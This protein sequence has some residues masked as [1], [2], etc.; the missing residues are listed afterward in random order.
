MVGRL[1]PRLIALA[2]LWLFCSQVVAQVPPAPTAP[3]TGATGVATA[4]GAAA[5]AAPAPANLWSF[6]CMTPAQKAACKQKLCACPLVQ[7]LGNVLAPARALSG[8]LLPRYCPGPLD[9]NP[10]DLALPPDTPGGAASRIKEKEAQAK[11]RRAD[12]RYLGTVDCRRYPEAEAAL[13]NALRGDEN[14]CVRWEAALA[15]GRGCCCTRKVLQA[16]VDTVS[17]KKTNEPAE[18]SE[19]VKAAAAAA[20]EHCLLCY[21]E[22]I[23]AAPQPEKPPE[24]RPEL[25]P[26]PGA[27]RAGETARLAP[28][29]LLAEA[30]RV[31]ARHR[32]STIPVA[33][34]AQTTPPPLATARE[35]ALLPAGLS[36]PAADTAARPE[37]PPAEDRLRSDNLPPTGQR[38]VWNVLRAALR[39]R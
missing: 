21:H 20:L 22:I 3:A 35:P 5:P 30:R 23:T 10:A 28:D 1:L 36:V 29:A 19:R 4:A 26:E 24:T 39:E 7:F 11:K 34:P 14:E 18:T 38:D 27:P 2:V 9:P 32:S 8:G 6:L 33:T 13:V 31:L 37:P 12:V 17:G 25:P 16:L 15:L